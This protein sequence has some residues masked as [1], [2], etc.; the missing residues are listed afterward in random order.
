VAIVLRD[1]DTDRELGTITE[2]QLQ[3]LRDQLEEETPQDQD[4]YLTEDTLEAFA[5]AGC[6]PTLLALLRKAM[7]GRREL[8]IRWVRT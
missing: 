1:K 8:E 3:F 2:D 7:E 4:Y 5:E 6:D